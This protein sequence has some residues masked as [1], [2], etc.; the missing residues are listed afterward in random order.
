MKL[1]KYMYAVLA[2]IISAVTVVIPMTETTNAYSA[3][4]NNISE[5]QSI[6]NH[7]GMP[8]GPVDGWTGPKTRRGLCS[9]RLVSS[10]DQNPQ[11]GQ[12]LGAVGLRNLEVNDLNELRNFRSTY[13]NVRSIAMNNLDGRSTYVYINKTCQVGMYVE[14]NTLMRVFP[15]STGEQGKETPT[16]AWRL[17]GTQRG[18]SCS[19]LYPSSCV[20]RNYDRFSSYGNYGNMYNKR[21]VM[22]SIFVHGSTR[23]PTY[24]GSKGCIRITIA[25]S[26]WFYDEVGNWDHKN[27]Y[28]K[29]DGAYQW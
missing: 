19:T 6:M 23:V 3:S 14:D 15:V 29:I 24:P 16:G 9:F 28:I 10:M 26:N 13:A 22:G 4:R 20:Y 1:N 8:A 12:A 5:A 2:L 7:Y 11:T 17:G 27:P 18:W 25:D 21:Y